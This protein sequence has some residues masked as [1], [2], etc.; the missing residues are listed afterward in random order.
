AAEAGQ[1]FEEARRVAEGK[2]NSS[3][4]IDLI[5]LSACVG[6]CDVQSADRVLQH[7][8][9][10]H[11]REPGIAQALHSL[12]AQWGIIRPD[13]SMAAPAGEA[14]LGGA[15]SPAAAEAPGKIWTPGGDPAPG[16]GK[17]PAIWTPGM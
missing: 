11:L 9:N 6:R 5:E 4:R 14:V 13:G 2:G 17:K 1:L 8:R 10:E 3:A 7:I 16:G 15:S 12:L